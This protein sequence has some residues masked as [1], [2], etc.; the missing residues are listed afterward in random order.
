MALVSSG[1]YLLGAAHAASAAPLA[2]AAPQPINAGKTCVVTATQERLDTA[3]DLSRDGLSS[4]SADYTGLHPSPAPSNY[5]CYADDH[6]AVAAITGG[7]LNVPENL[8][9]KAATDWVTEH[10]ASPGTVGS[11]RGAH[12][13]RVPRYLPTLTNLVAYTYTYTGTNYTGTVTYLVLPVVYLCAS[14]YTGYG[15]YASLTVNLSSFLV[16]SVITGKGQKALAFKRGMNGLS[17][18]LTARRLSATSVRVRKTFLYRLYPTKEQQRLLAR[19]LEECRWLWNHLLAERRD[20]WEQR[21]ET[22]RLY[23]Q[24]TTLPMLKAERPALAGVHSQVLQNVAV[25]LDLAFKAFFRRVQAG[26][27]EPGYPRFRGVGRYDSLTFPQVPVGCRLVE[28]DGQDGRQD[29]KRHLHIH[30]VGQIKVVWHRPLD[31]TPKT[32][33]IRRHS[34]GKWYV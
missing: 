17:R 15:Y 32:A 4:N 16:R 30:R 29:S 25:R 24:Q 31:G 3:P 9:G 18:P 13:V 8:H 27:D 21:Q 11:G 23:D 7:V 26:E 2:V 6:S 28:S 5:R 12:V 22:L 33:T 20:A 14:P 1:T 10:I 19:Q 34:T